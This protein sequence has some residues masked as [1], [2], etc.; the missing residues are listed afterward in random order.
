MAELRDLQGID[1]DRDLGALMLYAMVLHDV[2]H[3]VD[4]A[5]TVRKLREFDP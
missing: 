3:H 5:E 1:F 2:E 4:L